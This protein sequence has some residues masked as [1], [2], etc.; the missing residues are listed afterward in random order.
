MRVEISLVVFVVC[1]AVAPPSLAKKKSPPAPLHVAKV[2][3]TATPLSPAHD[4]LSDKG[5]AW[6]VPAADVTMI[7]V[8]FDKEVTVDQ[9]NVVPCDGVDTD[10]QQHVAVVDWTMGI[11]PQ[12]T[13]NQFQFSSKTDTNILVIA[14]ASQEV[15]EICLKKIEL[16]NHKAPFKLVLP[17]VVDG[18]VK[19]SNTLDGYPEMNL[20]DGR[21]E[22]AWSTKGD[23]TGTTIDLDLSSA[24]RFDGVRLANGYWRSDDLWKNN[25]RP[26]TM[27]VRWGAGSKDTAQFALRAEQGGGDELHKL[28]AAVTAKKVSLTIDEVAKGKKYRDTVISELRLYDGDRPIRVDNQAFLKSRAQRTA[29]KLK[30][31]KLDGILGREHIYNELD[32][33]RRWG[34]T[35]HADGSLSLFE[36]VFSDEYA[37]G[38]LGSLSWE[39]K[40]VDAKGATVRLFGNLQRLSFSKDVTDKD[41]AGKPRSETIS[42]TFRLTPAEHGFTLTKKR[43]AKSLPLTEETFL[44][45]DQ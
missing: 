16:R 29:K 5:M 7:W 21:W 34:L 8:S 3:T 36:D 39:I 28:P 32:E 9:V 38:H 27:S 31:A 6:R 22:Y 2:E 11:A 45:R 25:S 23:G 17:Q 14:V 20:F 30:R 18:A 24:V 37:Y 13:P 35:F 43:G 33:G 1:V 44:T 10:N 19:A 12:G 26:K 40:K 15:D 41:L 42:G 4:L